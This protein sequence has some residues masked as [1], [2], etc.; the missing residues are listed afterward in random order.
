[1]YRYSERGEKNTLAKLSYCTRPALLHWEE[2]GECEE[3]DRLNNAVS[4]KYEYL[5][6]NNKLVARDI[7]K[8]VMR[9]NIEEEQKLKEWI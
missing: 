1:M 6:N 7:R 5:V 3:Q 8:I 4:N 2:E 9:L